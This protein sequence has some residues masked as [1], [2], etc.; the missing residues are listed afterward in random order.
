MKKAVFTDPAQKKH[1]PPC[2]IIFFH[3]LIVILQIVEWFN[4]FQFPHHIFIWVCLK[5]G[6]IPNEIAI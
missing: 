5:I 4:L 6:Y 1:N 3:Q 2:I